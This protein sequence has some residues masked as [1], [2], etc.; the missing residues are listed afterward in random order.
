MY[1]VNYRARF[2]LW[3]SDTKIRALMMQDAVCHPL[4]IIHV[5]SLI[6]TQQYP[7]SS[8]VPSFPVLP[9]ILSLTNRIII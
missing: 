6:Y 3:P 2:T 5:H 9:S 1:L 8:L 4:I 7:T